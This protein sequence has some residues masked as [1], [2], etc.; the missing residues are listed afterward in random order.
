MF[1]S[2]LI[3]ALG[4]ALLVKGADWLIKGSST[5]A[6]KFGLSEIAIGLTVVAFGTSAPEL[7]VNVVGSLRT[8]GE[9]VVG[10]IVG[11]NIANIALVLGS[12]G[13]LAPLAIE[14][15]LIKKDIPIGILGIAAIYFLASQSGSELVLGH[16]AG[17]LL[18]LGFVGFLWLIYRAAK[19]KPVVAEAEAPL[20]KKEKMDAGM[21]TIFII[22]GLLALA[23]GGEF[24]VD[25]AIRIAR[26]FGVSEKLIG[27]TLVAIGTSLPELVTSIVAVWRKKI[28]LAIGN[29]VGS[30][31]FNIFWV[32]GVSAIIAPIHF[33]SAIVTDLIVLAGMSLIL[34][35]ANFIGKK[36]TLDRWQAA[37]LLTSYISYIGF[38]IYRG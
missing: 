28:D 30:N 13:L 21:A 5:L 10:N 35:A 38:I 14:R 37:I 18:I 4:F 19:K 17:V 6:K 20:L 9:I 33:S 26:N 22:S 3:F 15:G 16:L 32:L 36:Y 23:L 7:V 2:Y 31:V 11:S 27:L 24:V 1:L 34:M 8:S 25:S 12:A 29:V